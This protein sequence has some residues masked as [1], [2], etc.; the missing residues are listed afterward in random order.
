MV[1]L[2]SNPVKLWSDTRTA[3][4]ARR[5]CSATRGRQDPRQVAAELRR[6]SAVTL[7]RLSSNSA[8]MPTH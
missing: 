4:G 5:A 1:L 8:D 7:A 6:V 2:R 3:P